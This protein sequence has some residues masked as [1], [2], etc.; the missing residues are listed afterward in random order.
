MGRC[1]RVRKEDDAAMF[2]DDTA[3]ATVARHGP[4]VACA[5][6]DE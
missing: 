4:A 3:G 1:A 2:A 5:G 6:A